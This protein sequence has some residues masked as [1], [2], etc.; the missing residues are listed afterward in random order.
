MLSKCANPKCATELRYLRSGKVFKM[1][2]ASET[3]FVVSGRKPGRR[4]EHFWLC[5]EC[6]E[7]L[8]LNSKD[9]EIQVVPKRGLAPLVRAAAAS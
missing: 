9:D 4:V 1:E 3:P 2:T 6:A 8:T 5:G 7:H